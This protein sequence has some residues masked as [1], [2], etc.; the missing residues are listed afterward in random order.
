[1]NSFFLGPKLRV[2]RTQPS[3]LREELV[4]GGDIGHDDTLTDTTQQDQLDT[5]ESRHIAPP[6]TTAPAE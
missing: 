4:I 1:L 5:P 2:L 6:A 3:I